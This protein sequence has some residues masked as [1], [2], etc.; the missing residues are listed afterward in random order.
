MLY[1]ILILILLYNNLQSG[2]GVG[3][4]SICSGQSGHNDEGIAGHC[5]RQ[6]INTLGNKM[7]TSNC[8]RETDLLCM[9]VCVRV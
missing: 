7:Q 9:C 5:A 2:G 8:G 1:N 3:R 4:P 6:T